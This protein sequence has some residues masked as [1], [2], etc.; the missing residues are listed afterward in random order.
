VGRTFITQYDKKTLEWIKKVTFRNCVHNHAD[1]LR[2]IQRTKQFPSHLSPWRKPKYRRWGLVTL[3]KL[4]QPPT[5][6][7]WFVTKEALEVLQ[8]K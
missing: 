2:Y 1:D 4:G 6:S 8:S 7:E 5:V 3:R